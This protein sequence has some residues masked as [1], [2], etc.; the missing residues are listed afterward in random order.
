ML[1]TLMPGLTL[2]AARYSYAGGHGIATGM[3]PGY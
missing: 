2:I 3:P 1:A